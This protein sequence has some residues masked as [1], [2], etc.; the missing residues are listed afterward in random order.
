MTERSAFQLSRWPQNWDPLHPSPAA[1]EGLSSNRSSSR[2]WV[3]RPNQTETSDHHRYGYWPADA[4]LLK[5]AAA[6]QLPP[7]LHHLT[8]HDPSRPY[9]LST[10]RMRRD[11][12]GCISMCLL[13]SKAILAATLIAMAG[14]AT[15]PTEQ[16]IAGL[17]P[18]GT[19]S[20]SEDFVVGWA[21]G[22]G[23]LN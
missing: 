17:S 16:R 10:T 12:R 23:L 7:P 2:F 11:D 8:G 5:V 19:V 6:G 4:W 15:A 21:G 13:V 1:C 22:N 20:I 9:E 3:R 18:A 14:C